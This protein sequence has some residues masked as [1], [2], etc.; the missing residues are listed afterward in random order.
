MCR[1]RTIIVSENKSIP[2]SYMSLIF[3][4][5]IVLLIQCSVPQIQK[6][7]QI[8]TKVLL[9][10]LLLF[11][12]SY[13]KW[14]MKLRDKSFLWLGLFSIS[15]GANEKFL[16]QFHYYILSNIEEKSLLYCYCKT[17]CF[18]HIIRVHFKDHILINRGFN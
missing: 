5:Y 16:I 10:Q 8:E 18:F 4:G 17:F 9:G 14:T 12:L 11:L 2:M 15:V 6:M 13:N 1:E 7:S 3:F